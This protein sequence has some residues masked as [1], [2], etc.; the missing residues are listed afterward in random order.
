[1]DCERTFLDDLK[2][3]KVEI[4]EGLNEIKVKNSLCE[5]LYIFH[6]K[7]GLPIGIVR[8][9]YVQSDGKLRVSLE[10]TYSSK[11]LRN[12]TCK[13][14]NSRGNLICEGSYENG[15]LIGPEFEYTYT[16]GGELKKVEIN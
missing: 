6:I 1:M 12:G 16:I 8:G 11:G 9:F 14:Y 15:M 10:E 13:E 5:V 4:K 3:K 2:E 7:N